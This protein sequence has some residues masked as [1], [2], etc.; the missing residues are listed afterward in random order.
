MKY[1]I[2]VG[3]RRGR[4]TVMRPENC[5]KRMS[6]TR[7]I[8]K[9]DCGQM[10]TIR[11]D[12]L[13]RGE[14][15]SCGCYQAET[16]SIRINLLRPKTKG[17]RTKHPYEYEAWKGIKKRAGSN[18]YGPWVKSFEEFINH[19]GTR[20]ESMWTIGL[21][22]LSGK[23]EPGNIKWITR[24][25]NSNQ[26]TNSSRIELD[27]V[28]KTKAEWAREY[29]LTREIIKNRLD[30][31][32]DVKSAITTPRLMEGETL[33]P[34]KYNHKTDQEK[35]DYL[36][37]TIQTSIVKAGCWGWTGDPKIRGMNYKTF[38]WI[39][40]KG[41]IPYNK[42]LMATCANDECV[43][44]ESHLRLE[45]IYVGK[46]YPSEH[47]SWSS[48]KDRCLNKDGEGYKWYGARGI[49]VCERWIKSF[50]DFMTDVGPKPK[51]GQRLTLGRKDNDGNYEPGN[52]RWET[53][54]QQANNRR[55]GDNSGQKN[56]SAKLTNEQ[57]QEIY[58]RYWSRDR[59]KITQRELAVEYKI[60]IQQVS[61]LC[62][63]KRSES[64]E[65]RNSWQSKIESGT[66]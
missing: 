41:N 18:I 61:R 57:A 30:R 44:Y 2:I 13:V 15:T 17:L 43:N 22:N 54:K 26:R 6:K 36:E 31:G 59:Y 5:S 8:C 48:M 49:S 46:D 23:Y 4:W 1:R 21:I 12:V 62:R 38:I 33:K 47:N 35:F 14:S 63:G 7:W 51:T 16:A 29:G 3:E 64:A 19:I 58:N 37:N 53:D 55:K 34:V 32:W 25:E 56:G 40:Y 65:Q 50:H 66:E 20:P 9:C 39:R 60:S 27:G 42:R 24:L 10:G 52:V 11:Y 45:H 28:S